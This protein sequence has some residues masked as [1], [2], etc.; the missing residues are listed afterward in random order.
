MAI[1]EHP[2]LGKRWDVISSSGGSFWAAD[3]EVSLKPSLADF[4][5]V[6]VIVVNLG[7]L[8]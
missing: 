4:I 8:R 7:K 1:P 3:D 5:I 2:V 6:F